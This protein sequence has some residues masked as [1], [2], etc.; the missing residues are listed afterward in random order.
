M[1][2]C[3]ETLTTKLHMRAELC[4]VSI[5]CAV[6]VVPVVQKRRQSVDGCPYL[7]KPT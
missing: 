3:C 1:Y 6:I 7:P 2:L 4:L 5:S